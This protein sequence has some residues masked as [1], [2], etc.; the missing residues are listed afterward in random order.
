MKKGYTTL[1][2]IVF[3][4]QNYLSV[5]VPLNKIIPLKKMFSSKFAKMTFF[6]HVF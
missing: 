1:K 4:F 5:L 6:N 3:S 2:V